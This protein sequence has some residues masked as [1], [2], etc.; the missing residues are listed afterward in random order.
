MMMKMMLRASRTTAC[1]SHNW[2]KQ[3]NW[4]RSHLLNASSIVKPRAQAVDG[5][6]HSGKSSP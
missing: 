4:Q 5:A 2:V 3:L 1:A 6:V